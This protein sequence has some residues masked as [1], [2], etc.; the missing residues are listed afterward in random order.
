MLDGTLRNNV[1]YLVKY[2]F[3]VVSAAVPILSV[4][5]C[6]ACLVNQQSTNQL[7]TCIYK[8]L[9]FLTILCPHSRFLEAIES[10]VLCFWSLEDWV[11]TVLCRGS[12]EDWE[13]MVL[14]LG[15]REPWES[16]VSIVL[17]FW[18]PYWKGGILLISSGTPL[19]S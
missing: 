9:M 13:S 15:R 2:T 16:M 12:R 10:K 14:C 7:Y 5:S 6:L 3:L 19:L 1:T 11:S 8:H 18:S 4:N 17:C